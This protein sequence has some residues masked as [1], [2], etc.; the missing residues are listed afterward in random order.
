[1]Q[2]LLDSI[3]EN[4]PTR[5]SARVLSTSGAPWCGLSIAGKAEYHSP[6]P[7]RES[8]KVYSAVASSRPVWAEPL[9][10]LSHLFLM[11]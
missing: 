5:S 9:R 10:F 8:G 6:S 1:M 7:N 4:S 2:G 11:H 3:T